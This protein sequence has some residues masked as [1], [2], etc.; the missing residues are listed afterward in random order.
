M[1]EIE[2]VTTR[3]TNQPPAANTI[4]PWRGLLG[5][6]L[7]AIVGAMGSDIT[8]SRYYPDLVHYVP[9]YIILALAVGFGL[10]A[11]RSR[12]EMD[13]LLGMPVLFLGGFFVVYI[14]YWCLYHCVC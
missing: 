3:D 12:Q 14:V 10:S 5:F 9:R 2:T 13:L 11:V 7:L 1:A 8:P 4:L 6:I